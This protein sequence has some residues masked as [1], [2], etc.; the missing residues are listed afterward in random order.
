M[1]RLF[2]LL[3]LAPVASAGP[4]TVGFADIDVTPAIEAKTPVFMAGFGANRKATKVHDPLMARAVVLSDGTQKIAMVCTDVIGLFNDFANDVRSD[5]TGFTYVLVSSTHNHEGPDTMGLWGSSPFNS[6]VNEEYMKHLRANIVKAINTADKKAK[7]AT[8]KIAVVALPH[9][10]ED[11]RQPYVKHE[12]LVAIR[13]ESEGKPLGVLVQWNN[14]PETMASKN[15]EITSD[16]VGYTVGELA[17]RQRCPVAYFTGTVGGLMTTLKVPIKNPQGKLLEDGTW[18]KTEQLGREVAIEADKAL[19]TAKPVTLTPFEIRRREIHIPVQN[20]LYKLVWRAGVLK[21]TFYVWDN[22][23]TPFK[24]AT[25]E[26]LSKPGALRTELGYL[27]L[28]D[29][30][31][32]VIPGE[33]YPELVLNRVQDPADP[34]AD[35]PDA[36]IEPAIYDQLRAPYKMLIGLGNDEIGYI[37]PKRQWDKKPPFCYGRTKEQY[38]EMNSIGPDAAPIICDQFQKLVKENKDK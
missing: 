3:L 13:F 22:N 19:K 14:H 31:V 10:M 24:P 32:A 21:R 2:W 4:L 35:F 27:K 6:G 34:A 23:P 11:N 28:G 37:I 15:T 29:L 8:A 16:F 25:S 26:D 33:I 9:L 20:D 17:K 5:L 38:G 12:D 1:L 18:E 36:P 7:P 30:E